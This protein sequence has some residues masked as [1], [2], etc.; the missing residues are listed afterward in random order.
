MNKLRQNI[1]PLICF[2]I[3]ISTI[4]SYQ[5]F[6]KEEIV[7]LLNGKTTSWTTQIINWIYPRF[8][9]EQH[10]FSTNFFLEKTAMVFYRGTAVFFLLGTLTFAIINTEWLKTK[11]NSFWNQ[12]TNQTNIQRLNRLYIIFVFFFT[13][14]L[15]WDII[16]L[17]TAAP[18]FYQPVFIHKI[19]GLGFPSVPLTILLLFLFYSALLFAFFNKFRRWSFLISTCLFIYFEGLLNGFEKIDHGFATFFYTGFGLTISNFVCDATKNKQVPKWPILL[20][21]LWICL[22]Y[23]LAGLEKITISGLDWMFSIH[24]IQSHLIALPTPLGLIISEYDSI[25]FVI[26]FLTFFVQF[27]F[28][29]ILFQKRLTA[30]ILLIG[31]SF[32]WG[33]TLL[34]GISQYINPWIAA[35]IIFIDWSCIPLLLKLKSK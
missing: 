2:F 26:M 18:F 31:I 22:S 35:Y 5:W 19:L 1:F 9:V 24:S 27:G 30:T 12:E 14:A 21:Q 6:F 3:A 33:T 7:E 16:D 13:K 32:H 29:S 34:L 8:L 28:I 15:I 10:R 23:F 17:Q 20:T 4:T 11:W 25:C